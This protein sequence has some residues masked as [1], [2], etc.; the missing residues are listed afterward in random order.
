M[1]TEQ[2][3]APYASTL[4]IPTESSDFVTIITDAEGNFDV[5]VGTPESYRSFPPPFTDDITIYV[6]QIYYNPPG[7]DPPPQNKRPYTLTFPR[8]SGEHAQYRVVVYNNAPPYAGNM[9]TFSTTYDNNR[10]WSNQQAVP[11]NATTDRIIYPK[12]VK[13]FTSRQDGGWS[14]Y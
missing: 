5:P 3:G 14:F 9:I 12:S 1:T 13:L 11:H 10:R 8:S 4:D 7:L 2:G 6:H